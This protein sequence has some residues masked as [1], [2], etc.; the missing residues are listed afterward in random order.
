LLP[1]AVVAMPHLVVANTQIQFN[2]G[3]V[4]AGNANMTFDKTAGNITLGNL[5]I[6]TNN[7]NVNPLLTDTNSFTST[8]RPNPGRIGVGAGYGGDWGTTNDTQNRT[9]NARLAVVDRVLGS[10]AGNTTFASAVN[11]FETAAE[12]Y[13]VNDSGTRITDTTAFG[14]GRFGLNLWGPSAF[15]NTSNGVHLVASYNALGAAVNIGNTTV[16]NANVLSAVGTAGSV[17]VN[18]GSQ[19]NLAISMLSGSTKSWHH[20]NLGWQRLQC[21]VRINTHS[22][23]Q[24]VSDT[25]PRSAK[26]HLVNC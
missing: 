3:G 11:W 14:A 10:G 26:Q 18:S 5:L 15:G 19:A 17:Q 7:A 6:Q 8:T 20:G 1:Q 12:F 9:R 21:Y 4:F 2:D 16:G 22:A 23:W 24:R 25:Q 13:A